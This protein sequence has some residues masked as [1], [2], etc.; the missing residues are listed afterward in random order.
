MSKFSLFGFSAMTR[1]V[2]M[3]L[4]PKY[5]KH[6]SLAEVSHPMREKI[7]TLVTGVEAYRS[8]EAIN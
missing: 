1:I 2:I 5:P 6:D 3:S 8:R 4:R 7:K